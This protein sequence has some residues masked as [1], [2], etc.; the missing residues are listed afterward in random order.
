MGASEMRPELASQGEGIKPL[1]V[2]LAIF[3]FF[4]VGLFL[5]WKHPSLSRNKTW[6]WVGGVWSALIVLAAANG[7]K[8]KKT[9]DAQ[10]GIA[11]NNDQESSPTPAT[12]DGQKRKAWEAITDH[13]TE[14]LKELGEDPSRKEREA[15]MKEV[16][17]LEKQFMEIPFDGT[18]HP[19]DA[20][21]MLIGYDFLVKFRG[22]NGITGRLMEPLSEHMEKM[23]KQYDER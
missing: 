2:G 16:I 1:Y 3:F 21:Q 10:T 6:W 20:R 11:T 22:L 23:R 14:G 12:D 19:D 17:A 4:P 13:C 9:T 8:D 15:Y 5:L 7:D 18:K